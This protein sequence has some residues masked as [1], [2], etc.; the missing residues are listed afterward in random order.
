MICKNVGPLLVAQ[1]IKKPIV[2]NSMWQQ[3]GLTPINKRG[4]HFDFAEPVKER[5]QM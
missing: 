2:W 3:I 1:I 5:M 4:T